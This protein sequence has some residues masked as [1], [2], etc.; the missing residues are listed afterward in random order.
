MAINQI[1]EDECQEPKESQLYRCY[2]EEGRLLCVGISFDTGDHLPASWLR[3]VAT[4]RVEHFATRE[5]AVAAA[6][7][8][9]VCEAPLYNVTLP[10]GDR[11]AAH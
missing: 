2:A 8:A 3:E 1:A 4:V 10:P 7:A 6:R 11:R 5:E 9:I